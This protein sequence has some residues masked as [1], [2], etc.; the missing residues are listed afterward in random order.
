MLDTDRI[1]Y[2][3]AIDRRDNAYNAD[4]V[5]MVDR[6]LNHV[7]NVSATEVGVA[8]HTASA[9]FRDATIPGR[10]IP[11]RFKN[12]SQAAAINSCGAGLDNVGT[13]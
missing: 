9:V 12:A 11:N 13:F 6:Y 8:G 2:A 7:G 4:I 3:A 5:V 1:N 10:F